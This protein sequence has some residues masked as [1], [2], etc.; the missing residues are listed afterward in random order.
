MNVRKA[1][2]MAIDRDARIVRTIFSGT[3]MPARLVREPR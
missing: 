1:I 3:Q 2:S